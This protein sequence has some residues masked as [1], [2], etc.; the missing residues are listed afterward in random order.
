MI[1]K[2]HTN[3]SFFMLSIQIYNTNVNERSWEAKASLNSVFIQ[4]TLCSLTEGFRL[5]GEH[6]FLKTV[7]K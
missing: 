6:V 7:V 1:K 2:R 4:G 5:K 3:L